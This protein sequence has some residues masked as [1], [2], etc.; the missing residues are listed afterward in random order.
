MGKVMYL[1]QLL[2]RILSKNP[3][4]Q[5]DLILLSCFIC[6]KSLKYPTESGIKSHKVSGQ[7]HIFTTS[8]NSEGAPGAE[9]ARRGVRVGEVLAHSQSGRRWG[10]TPVSDA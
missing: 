10:Q 2:T 5:Q 4:A 8:G 6:D 7:N 9:G 1:D 3:D